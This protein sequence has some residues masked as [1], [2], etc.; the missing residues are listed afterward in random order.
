[1]GTKRMLSID[2]GEVSTSSISWLY[3]IFFDSSERPGRN[4][5]EAS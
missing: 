5:G 3:V 1:L 2:S 4:V